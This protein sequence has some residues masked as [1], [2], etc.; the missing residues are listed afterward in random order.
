[1]D[2]SSASICSKLKEPSLPTVPSPLRDPEAK[3][4]RLIPSPLIDQ[5]NFV[6]AVTLLVC[7]VV[8]NK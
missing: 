4:A 2:P 1:M 3:S 5:Y 8:V 7:A 6:P